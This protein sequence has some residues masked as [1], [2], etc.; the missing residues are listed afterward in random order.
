MTLVRP[1]SIASFSAAALVAGLALASAAPASAQAK[2]APAVKGDPVHGQVVYN[3]CKVC[4]SLDA[5]KNGVGP[6]L[7]GIVGTKAG[8]VAGYTFS[9]AM[10]KSGI[11]W[12]AAE[13]SAF[14]QSP[15]Q[16]ADR[17]AELF[18]GFVAG[19]AGQVAQQERRTQSLRQTLQ[20]LVEGGSHFPPDEIGVRRGRSARGR[21]SRIHSGLG[22][23]RASDLWRRR[24]RGHRRLR[25]DRRQ[26]QRQARDPVL[27]A[28]AC[29][30]L[31]SPDG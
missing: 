4:H 19:Q 5:G 22:G 11:T 25:P 6:S 26:P 2:K 24:R 14:L 30:C 29:D 17:P 27:L 21:A 28:V 8:D 7:K 18:R 9:P 23:T 31:R 13:L 10:K 15:L 16:G 3:Q 20:F 12:T 1:I